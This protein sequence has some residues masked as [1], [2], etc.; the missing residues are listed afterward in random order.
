[1]SAYALSSDVSS[2]IDT[3]SANSAT[4]A[5]ASA[6]SAYALSADVSGCI[7]TVSSNSASWAQVVTSLSGNA[8]FYNQINSKSI[9]STVSYKARLDEN[10]NSISALYNT[11][12]AQ[13][14]NW[15]GS[16]LALSAGPGIVFNKVGDTLVASVDETV[17][18]E[19]SARLTSYS[20]TLSDS[21]HNYKYVDIYVQ[22]NSADLNKRGNQIRRFEVVNAGETAELYFPRTESMENYNEVS[23]VFY[24]WNYNN[25]LDFTLKNGARWSGDTYASSITAYRG[26]VTK[27]VGVCKI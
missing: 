10:G 20:S 12:S 9:S 17:L 16:A 13:S 27:I 19:G 21:L 15:G 11:V 23:E 6:I 14:A 22:P 18:W 24:V 3:V 8:N 7:D 25:G 5:S 4:W 26:M 1:M 2:T